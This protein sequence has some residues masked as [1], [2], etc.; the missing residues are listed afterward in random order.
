MRRF[1]RHYG[2]LRD[3][4]QELARGRLVRRYQRD[5]S[6]VSVARIVGSVSK[7]GS[8]DR[9]FRYKSGK[10][11]ARLRHLREV[12]R[13]GMCAL[14]PVELY[15]LNDEYYVVDGHHRVALALENRQPEI[16]ADVLAHEVEHPDGGSDPLR[17]AA[18]H[19]SEPAARAQEHD[20]AH[21]A[22]WAGLKQ[23][24]PRPA[25]GR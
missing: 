18:R 5:Y 3:F 24:W 7:A 1:R 13:W 6:S 19:D 9:R 15:Q 21:R 11:D 22:W 14:P 16:D 4:H 17:Q 20:P 10:V 12:N 2:N 8:M 23:R 25:W